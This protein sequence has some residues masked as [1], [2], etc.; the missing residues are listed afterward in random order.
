[1]GKLTGFIAA[2]VLMFGMG[3]ASA[4]ETPGILGAADYQAM[5][6]S[7]M[8]SVTGE[9]RIKIRIKN[10]NFNTNINQQTQCLLGCANV[11]VFD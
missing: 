6:K 2:A 3:A 9:N 8:S 10:E 5:S 7:E 4:A 1:M 11:I